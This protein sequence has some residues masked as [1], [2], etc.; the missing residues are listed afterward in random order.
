MLGG[1][2]DANIFCD[3]CLNN[4]RPWGSGRVMFM[5]SAATRSMILAFKRKDR[6]Y[7]I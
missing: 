7:L 5:Y 2:N 4:P 3:D 1:R 6:Y